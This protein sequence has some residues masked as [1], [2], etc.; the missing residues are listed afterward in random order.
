MLGLLLPAMMISGCGASDSHSRTVAPALPVGFPAELEGARLLYQ[1]PDGVYLRTLGRPAAVKVVDRGTCPRWAADGGSFAFLRGDEV[2]LFRLSDQSE[3]K[4]ARTSRAR[5]VAVHP[6]GREVFFTDGHSIVAVDTGTRSSRVVVEDR[7]ALELDISPGGDFLVATVRSLG[8]RVMRYDLPSGR[9]TE[10]GKGCSAGVSADN[11]F[12][13][14]NLDGHTRLALKDS[15]TGE[16]RRLLAAPDGHRLDNHKW[17]NHTD[18]IVAITEG[19]Q[20][21]ILI[22][23]VSD[24]KTWRITEEGDGDRPDLWIP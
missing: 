21:D 10:I 11:R 4:L 14:V 19:R 6:D 18:W 17:S 7:E 1:R 13:T 8:Y 16:L 22:Q 9:R 24:G 12:I 2:M 20:Q 15:R 23:R 3:Q 5:S